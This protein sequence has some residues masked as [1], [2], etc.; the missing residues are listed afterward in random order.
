[1]ERRN[2]ILDANLYVYKSAQDLVNSKLILVKKRFESYAYSTKEDGRL[3]DIKEIITRIKDNDSIEE[4]LLKNGHNV[5]FEDAIQYVRDIVGFRIIC[6]YEKDIPKIVSL[7]EKLGFE[8]FRRKD[9]VT[10]PKKSGYRSYHIT[11]KIP[12]DL[13]DQIEIVLVEI[14]I[15]T[16]FMDLWASRE[17]DMIYKT[18]LS[19]SELISIKKTLV[20]LAGALD[21]AAAAMQSARITELSAVENLESKESAK[22]KKK[23][24]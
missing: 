15:R 1:M 17:H 7:I 10:E 21:L 3:G 9:Y 16:D 20:S 13:G 12:V 8:V 6:M 5:S 23:L 4:K 11:L 14:Q 24:L 19:E 18:T 22:Q 2:G